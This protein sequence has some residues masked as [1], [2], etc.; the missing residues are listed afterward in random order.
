M[1]LVP[2]YNLSGMT[3]ELPLVSVIVPAYNAEAFIEQ[4]LE[5][6][7][8]QTYINLEVL[9]VDD[10]SQ[11][12]TAELVASIARRD[13]RVLLLQQSNLGVAAARNLAIQKSKG[14][15]IAPIDA[16][17]IWHPQKI[18]KQVQCLSQAGP[19]VGL[20]YAWS[21]HIDEQNFIS[22]G[23]APRSLSGLVGAVYPTLVYRNFVGNASA[24]LIR[25]TCFEQVGGYNSELKAQNAQGCEDWELYLRIAEVY[26]F[27]V[28]PEFLIGYRQVGGSMACNGQSMAKSRQLVMTQIQQR[29]PEIPATIFR[30]SRS[31][32]YLY[33]A[34]KSALSG[35][36]WHTLVWLYQ[37]LRLDPALLVSFRLYRGLIFSLAKMIMKPLATL[38]W[39]DQRTWLQFKQQ[40]RGNQPVMTLCDINQ[41]SQ[42]QRRPWKPY[43][44]I[45]LQR[46]SEVAKHCE[47]T[48]SLSVRPRQ[49]L[50]G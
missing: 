15:Y 26:Q 35:D 9:V 18:E 41:Y 6:V 47:V 28:V 39:Q 43:E 12:G 7:L 20:V 3:A 50:P 25:R 34:S 22:G 36:H 30:W 13:R 29:H 23:A 48:T 19:S 40:L 33:L 45:L 14:E 11:D 8:S 4:T 42:Q 24:P 10:G 27:Q 46:W 44:R 37:A 17:D 1:H 21:V 5:S 32:F 2:H 31:Y 38:I 16:D 49:K